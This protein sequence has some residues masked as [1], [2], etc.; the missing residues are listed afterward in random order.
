[1]GTISFVVLTDWSI[2]ESCDIRGGIIAWKLLE[3]ADV[4]VNVIV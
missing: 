1:M 4:N 2:Y 3:N